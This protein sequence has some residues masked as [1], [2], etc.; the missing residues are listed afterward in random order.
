M[1]STLHG[2]RVAILATHGFE[3]SEL[4]QPLETLIKAGATVEIVSLKKG[5][6]KSWKNNNWG[7]EYEAVKGIDEVKSTQYYALVLPG[8][9][10][11]PDSLRV[12]EDAVN[13]V[14]D[15]LE[16]GKPLAAI[17]HGPWTMIETRLLKGRRLTSYPSIR[18]DLENA[19]AIWED[20]EVIVDK[21]LVSSRS[22]KDLPAFCKKLVE[23]IMEGVHD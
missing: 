13:F 3:Q 5:K 18:T 11:N 19:G 17:C 8:G 9:V 10:M 1:E 6:I 2:K 23:E 7:D 12:N 20:E 21:G 15:F 22:P 16:E 14:A 4:Q